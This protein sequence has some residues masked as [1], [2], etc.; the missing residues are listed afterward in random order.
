MSIITLIF[1]KCYTIIVKNK[2]RG[3][4]MNKFSTIILAAGEGSRMKSNMPKVVH[5]VVGKPMISYVIESAKEAGSERVVVV[6]G[7]KEN[8]VRKNIQDVLFAHQ[9]KQLG[10]GHAVMAANDYISDEGNV[11][12]LYGDT[13]LITSETLKKMVKKHVKSNAGVTVMSAMVDDPI[14]YGRIVRKND[15]FLKI[16]EHKDATGNQVLIKEINT[17]VYCFKAKELKYALSK[18]NNYNSQLEYYLTDTLEIILNHGCGIRVMIADDVNEFYGVNSRVQLAAAEEMMR[19]RINDYH[20]LNGVTIINPSATYIGKDVIIGKDTIVYP[21]TTIEG[22]TFIGE[23]CIIGSSSDIK[24]SKLGNNIEI[25]HSVI[26][27]SSIGNGTTVG[28]FAYIRPNSNIGENVKIGDFVEVKNS[29]IGNNT[30]AS[31]LTYLGDAD[32][33]SDINIGCGTITV[34]YDGKNKNRTIIEDNSFVGCN[35]NLIAPVTIEKNAYIAAGSTITDNVPTGSL[36]IARERQS[37]KKNW[38]IR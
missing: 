14:G 8:E 11:V 12:V 16:V 9:D 17:G 36:G 29:N 6:T 5:K 26:L 23:N 4:K 21:N 19:K 31:H 38:H 13:P 22:N 32:I 10:T 37:I 30:K 2:N 28:P 15:S 24:N 33:G 1:E 25:E 27:D 18:L 7:H 35:S 20:M 34:N 3:V